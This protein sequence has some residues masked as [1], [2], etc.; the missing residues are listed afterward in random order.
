MLKE[1][2][3]DAGG[4]AIKWASIQYTGNNTPT[5]RAM[6]LVKQCWL[7]A[8]QNLI[9]KEYIKL[10]TVDEVIKFMYHCSRG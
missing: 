9:D 7:K 5:L 1:R 8:G 4:Q 3:K 2:R 6:A 10:Q